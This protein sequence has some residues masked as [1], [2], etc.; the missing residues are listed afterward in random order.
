MRSSAAS[1][2]YKRQVVP[3]DTTGD[4]AEDAAEDE[5]EPLEGLFAVS[6][7]SSNASIGEPSTAAGTGAQ[8]GE[9]RLRAMAKS[10]ISGSILTY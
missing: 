4:K 7:S 8:E 3:E 10:Q 2:V 5:D 9:D 1:D 6:K